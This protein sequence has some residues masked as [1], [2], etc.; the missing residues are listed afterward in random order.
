MNSMDMDTLRRAMGLVKNLSTSLG[1]EVVVVQCDAG[2][3]KVM[4]TK[5][6]MKEIASKKFDVVGQGG[7]DFTEGFDYIWKKMKED[8]L[9]FGAP[10]VVFTDGGITVPDIQPKN[11]NMQVLWVTAP[12]HQAPTTKWGQ[13][14]IMDD[15]GERAV[16]M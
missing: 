13:H 8:D 11:L 5:Q 7:S 12:G 6:A 15:M 14:I 3:T 2:L 10:I 16:G 1:L 4:D 9:G